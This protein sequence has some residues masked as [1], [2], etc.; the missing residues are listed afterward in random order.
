MTHGPAP[1][2]D[3]H[4]HVVPKVIYEGDGGAMLT[5]TPAQF[6]AQ[7]AQ[8]SA[9]KWRHSFKAAGA[10]AWLGLGSGQGAPHTHSQ[11]MTG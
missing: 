9:K 10:A 11:D 2:T 6:E 8:S 1:Q 5:T 7:V 3:S 4:G